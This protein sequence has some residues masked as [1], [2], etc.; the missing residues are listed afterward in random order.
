MDPVKVL[1]MLPGD[2]ALAEMGNYFEQVRH[3]E[4]MDDPRFPHVP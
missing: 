4:W 3:L 1:K 2:I